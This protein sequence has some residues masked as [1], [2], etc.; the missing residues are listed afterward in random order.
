MSLVGLDGIIRA[1][2][3]SGPA[4]VGESIA[5]S[6]MMTEL[7]HRTS[8]SMTRRSQIDGVERIFSFRKVREYPL[9]VVVGQAAEEI[10][11]AYG[12]YRDQTLVA[13]A[14]LSLVIAVVSILIFRYQAGLAK[15]RDDAEAGTRARSEFLAMMSHEIRT[16][17]NGVIG[18]ADLLV[19]GDLPAEQKRLAVTLRDSADHPPEILNDVLDMSKLDAGRLEIEQVEFDHAPI[20]RGHH[21]SS[22]PARECQGLRA[23]HAALSLPI[24][25]HAVGRRP[26]AGPPGAVQSGR[27]RPS[28]SP[29]KAHVNRQASK[30]KTTDTAQIRAGL[31]GQPTP[32]SAF[33]MMRSAWLFRNSRRLTVRSPAG[34][35]A[36][37]SGSRFANG[38]SPAWAAK[39]RSESEDRQRQ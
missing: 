21:R 27:Q 31:Q 3:A 28:N 34:S 10:F 13:A 38:W 29:S 37:A 14:L 30:P 36:P 9:I 17:M 12:R 1:R 20:G 39:S 18:M 6:P 35:A 22:E 25:P 32:G 19:A 16:P 15:S 33:P 26:G 5:G 8:G 11:A 4:A 23:S 7:S 24:F 2:G